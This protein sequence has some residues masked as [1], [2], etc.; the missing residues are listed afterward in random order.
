MLVCKEML[1]ECK[2]FKVMK[3]KFLCYC[4]FQQISY[5]QQQISTDLIKYEVTES[6]F[7]YLDKE[8]CDLKYALTSL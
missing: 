5:E 8:F 2:H 1:K 7:Q 3:R 4:F 6:L